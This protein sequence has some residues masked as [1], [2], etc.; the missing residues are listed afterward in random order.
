MLRTALLTAALI[1][2][3]GNA[4][5]HGDDFIRANVISVVPQ[6]SLSFGSLR[7]DGFR[8]EYES[9][10]YRYSTFSD[11]YPGRVILVPQPLVVP[12]VP[13]VYWRDDDRRDWHKHDHWDER[14]HWRGDEHRHG[15][16]RG[17]HRGHADWR[18]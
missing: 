2:A 15:W 18:D 17:H 11:R 3:A 7:Q 9:G 13:R 12:V 10:G 4:N 14:R 1:V 8:V 16:N 5:A 6:L